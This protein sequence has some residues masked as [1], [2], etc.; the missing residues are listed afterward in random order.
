MRS[1][2]HRYASVLVR[3]AHLSGVIGVFVAALGGEASALWAG[4]LLL[5][6][7][8]L[9]LDDFWRFG[10]A[11]LRYLQCW[12]VVS[13]LVF[14]ALFCWA[15]SPLTGLCVAFLLGSLISHAPG[16]LR[17]LAL[18]GEPGPCAEHGSCKSSLMK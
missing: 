16:E 17:H 1:S 11:W 6:G 9:V 12:V 18:Q 10:V 4:V 2:P 14:F 7:L 8:L 5:S 3:T 15:G 13:K